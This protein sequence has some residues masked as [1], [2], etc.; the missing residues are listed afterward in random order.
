MNDDEQE[1]QLLRKVEEAFLLAKLDKTRAVEILLEWCAQDEELDRITIS[2][3]L[4]R[5]LR[6]W[7]EEGEEQH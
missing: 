7:N 1:K 6:D 5:I 4:E 2:R 3:A